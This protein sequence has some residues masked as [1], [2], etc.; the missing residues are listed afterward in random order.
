M[1]ELAGGGSVAVSVGVSYMWQVTHDTWQMTRKLLSNVTPITYVTLTN[2][3]TPMTHVTFNLRF[4]PKKMQEY[5]S[6][7]KRNF[8]MILVT[9]AEFCLATVVIYVWWYMQYRKCPSTQHSADWG[10][11]TH[12]CISRLDPKVYNYILHHRM[13]DQQNYSGKIY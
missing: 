12:D 2:H 5:W 1:G 3:V 8:L 7:K 11:L 9:V 6:N 10:H 4:P 13:I